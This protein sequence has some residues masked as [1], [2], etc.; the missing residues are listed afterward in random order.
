MKSLLTT[1]LLALL[2]F[3]TVAAQLSHEE[4]RVIKTLQAFEQAI[5]NSN[6]KAASELLSDKVRILEGDGIETKEEYLSHHFHADGKFLSAMNREIMSRSVF[7]EG[8]IAWVTTKSRLHEN[9]N[10]TPIDLTSL[11]LAVLKK[12]GNQWKIAALHWSSTTRK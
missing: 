9:Y 5:V 2:S 6:H 7:I 4:K 3:S 8:N 1:L 12:T 10:G 11:E